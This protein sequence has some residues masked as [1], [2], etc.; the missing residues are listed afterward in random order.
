MG[1]IWRRC[2]SDVEVIWKRYRCD[3]C[4]NRKRYGDVEAMWGRYGGDMQKSRPE[5]DLDQEP[6]S[7]ASIARP[8]WK[9]YRCGMEADLDQE[10]GSQASISWA[11]L[12]ADLNQE[13]D[14]GGEYQEPLSKAS[15]SR[16]ILQADC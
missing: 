8:I 7:H 11:I 14:L 9:R 13:P 5:A 2:G 12:A 3:L 10:P 15:I 1:T 6:F 4:L 16:S